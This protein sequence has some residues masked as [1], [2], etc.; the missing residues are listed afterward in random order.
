MQQFLVVEQ[1]VYVYFGGMVDCFFKMLVNVV[2][3]L[4]SYMLLLGVDF[5]DQVMQ[6]VVWFVVIVWVIMFSVLDNLVYF[7]VEQENGQVW[8]LVVGV[9]DKFYCFCFVL[10]IQLEKVYGYSVM[11]VFRL[12]LEEGLC[13][14]I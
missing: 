6:G 12:L 8:L 11:L 14:L 4:K 5:E 9:L 1:G 3:L 13:W 10:E 2:K 7:Y